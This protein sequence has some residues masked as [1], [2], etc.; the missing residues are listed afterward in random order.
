MFIYKKIV[1]MEV[2]VFCFSRTSLFY[3][4]FYSCVL[5]FINIFWRI[6]L[7]CN[8]LYK[9]ALLYYSGFFYSFCKL[10]LFVYCSKCLNISWCSH[11]YFY[12]LVSVSSLLCLDLGLCV[13]YCIRC[14][15]S[16]AYKSIYKSLFSFYLGECIF[17]IHCVYIFVYASLCLLLSVC[18]SVCM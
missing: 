2:C 14:L 9:Y 15:S 17:M 10:Y 18:N 16:H 7:S 3:F 5:S 13:I 6:S 8:V 11:T 12:L 1:Y 4:Y